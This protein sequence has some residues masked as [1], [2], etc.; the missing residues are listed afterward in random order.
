MKFDVLLVCWLNL[1]NPHPHIPTLP[2]C[3]VA[4]IV[5]ESFVENKFQLG[6]ILINMQVFMT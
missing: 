6:R 2:K 3:H 1:T 4:Q 5:Y